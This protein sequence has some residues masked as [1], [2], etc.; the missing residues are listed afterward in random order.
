MF[1]GN[2]VYDMPVPKMIQDENDLITWQDSP[3][4][5]DG[6]ADA[7]KSRQLSAMELDM[8][9]RTNFTAGLFTGAALAMAGAIVVQ[10]AVWCFSY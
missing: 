6:W 5:K 2:R 3:I 9:R 10:L 7:W 8:V 1:I 4:L